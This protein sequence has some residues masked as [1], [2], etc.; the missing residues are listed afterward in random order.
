MIPLMG[1]CQQW[2]GAWFLGRI[3]LSLPLFYLQAWLKETNAIPQ[4]L[5]QVQASTAL[6]K[7]KT[8]QCASTP[9]CPI[10]Q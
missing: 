6:I 9:L 3:F 5:S 8:L 4:S 1:T 7:F 10:S 2:N